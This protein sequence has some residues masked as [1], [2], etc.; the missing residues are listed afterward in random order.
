FFRNVGKTRRVGAELGLLG[1]WKR[2]DWFIN[3]G[4]VHATYETA[5]QAASANHPL[6]DG[7]GEIAVQE[8]DRIP[9][10]PEHS[11]KIGAEYPI[12]NRLSIGG[13]L[14]YNSDQYLRGD[15]ANLLDTIDGYA[16]V[17]VRGRY[18]IN[19]TFSIFARINNLFDTDYETFGLLGE[20]DE[21]FST[22]SDNRF[23]G[24][25]API[26]GFV[27]IKVEL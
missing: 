26:S 11:L 7:N 25:G 16:I 21:I 17:N 1:T 13:D 19:E 23:V 15:E 2:L 5:F 6:A 18:R 10:I 20:P 27:G 12:T 24:P 8:G 22:F 3:Y 4:F 14:L 9:G